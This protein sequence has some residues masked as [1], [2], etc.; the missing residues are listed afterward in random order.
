MFSHMLI[1]INEFRVKLAIELDTNK[2]IAIK[3]M[4]NS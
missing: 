4:K 1:N 2:Q 3:I